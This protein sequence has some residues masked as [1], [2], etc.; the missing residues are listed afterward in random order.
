METRAARSQAQ[1]GKRGPLCWPCLEALVGQQELLWD[2]TSQTLRATSH[3][4]FWAPCWPRD[5]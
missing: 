3:R 1:M 4:S 2:P 5:D